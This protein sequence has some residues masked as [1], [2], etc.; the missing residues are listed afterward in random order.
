MPSIH[1]SH[2]SEQKKRLFDFIDSE[3]EK[4][5]MVIGAEEIGLEKFMC[6]QTEAFL[7]K[8]RLF[9]FRYDIWP[10][11]HS[12]H[13][14]YRWLVETASGLA[15][16]DTQGWAAFIDANPGLQ[17]Q[18][19]LL[20]GRDQRPLEVRFLEAIRFIAEKM[21]DAPLVLHMAPL[22]VTHEP[23]LIEF[24]KSI[25]RMLPVKTKMI[26][27]QCTDDVMAV[28]DDFCPTNRIAVNGTT[29]GEIQKLLTRYYHC[30]HDDGIYGELMRAIVYLAHPLGIH[31]LSIFTGVSQEKVMAALASEVFEGMLVAHADK[32]IRLAYPRLF[33]PR[34]ETVRK[35][36]AEDRADMDKKVLAYYL[37][38]LLSRPK[39]FAALGHS[40]GVYR[41]ADARIT[42]NQALAGY[43]PKLALGAGEV[44]E[45][46]LQ[47]ALEQLDSSSDQVLDQ[48]SNSK[49]GHDLRYN[50]VETRGRLLLALGEVKETL[51]RNHDALEVLQK[52]VCVLR[53]SGD[54]IDLQKVFE[55]KGRSAFALRDIETA[56]DAFGEALGLA[57]EL[58]RTDLIADI[59]SQSAYLEF[60]IQQLDTAETKYREALEQ[61]RLL[62]GANP[63]LSCRGRALQWS[64]LGHVAYAR[65]N[66]E[67]A[68]AYHMKAIEIYG[69]LADDKK[70]AS[71]W[72]YLG[73]TY[74]A[75][76]N[77]EKAVNAYERAAE[78]DENAGEP[79]MAAQRYANMGH[80]MYA[81]REPEPAEKLF[82]TAMERYRALAN[83]E[84]EAA[85]L[86]NLG[87]VKGDQG[88][89][90]KA[91]DYFNRAKEMYEELGDRVNAVI[92]VIR[93]GHVQ[94]G[95]NDLKAAG[96]HY[97]NAM[98][99]Y[100]EL[101]YGLG[102]GDAAMELGQ[103]N[104]ILEDFGEADADFN[105]AKELFAKLGH[106]EKEAMC[107][108]LLSQVRKAQGDMDAAE[109]FLADAGVLFQQMGN[110][111]GRANV[112]F[113]TGLLH[114]D[115]KRYDRAERHYREALDI[116]REK[117]DQEGEANLLANFGTLYY[118]TKDLDS[119]RKEFEAAIALLRKMEHR[120][121][122]AGVLVNMSFVH[123][124]REDYSNAHSC[125]KEALSL[126]HEMKM[127][128]E[129]GTTEMRLAAVEHKAEIS[130]TRMR[131]GFLAGESGRPAKTD[132]IK[133]NEPCPCGSGKK[134]KKC[135][136]G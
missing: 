71:Q 118:E 136:H 128:R 27:C 93:L 23:A 82:R 4:V 76:R 121:G 20:E 94:R 42:A 12:R 44:G 117:A 47:R 92:Q 22:V 122:L 100:R 81:R 74:F 109:A 112:A 2:A 61:Y 15:C 95:Q 107:L 38:Q 101:D 132:K 53:E 63:A 131:G 126:Y 49:V 96:E 119:A 70:I 37:D 26:I 65:G 7:E 62:E 66:L 130:L 90:E 54:R 98:E 46:E 31:E 1:S 55:L 75:A 60:S 111:L 68:E 24:F 125:L 114:F 104:M 32:R 57:R 80:T 103:V 105:R 11:E 113:Q 116:F 48:V 18:L 134:A 51:S 67:Q 16:R 102:E 5:F 99:R 78:H 52:A 39:P 8:G 14:L 120:V 58:E 36:L 33:C 108:I 87:L 127:T 97:R 123:E 9:V 25:L 79:L 13:F 124:A 85:Q 29:P 133:R 50:P 77:Y 45:M 21:E 110:D 41:S 56:R 35:A 72:G 91:I 86:S 19:A 28:Q 135:C 89:F 115:Q 64:N 43:G 10:Q 88:E 69:I 34:D 59:L 129:A 3:T 30:Y 83:A 6:R 73:H 84:G 17:T 40:L 106:G